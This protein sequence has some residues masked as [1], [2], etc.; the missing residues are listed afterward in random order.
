MNAHEQFKIKHARRGSESRASVTG[1]QKL[2][3]NPVASSD[4]EQNLS[5]SRSLATVAN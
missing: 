2:Q 3:L 1:R 5:I 4:V